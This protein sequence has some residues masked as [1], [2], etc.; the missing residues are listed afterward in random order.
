MITRKTANKAITIAI[1]IVVPQPGVTFPY[2]EFNGFSRVPR[3]VTKLLFALPCVVFAGP[4]RTA[5]KKNLI[6]EKVN[7]RAL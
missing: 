3:L 7:L 4:F 6:I 1:T 2:S 5:I